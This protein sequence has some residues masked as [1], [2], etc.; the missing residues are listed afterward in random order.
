M[1]GAGTTRS[2]EGR[3][4]LEFEQYVLLCGEVLKTRSILRKNLSELHLAMTLA[5]SDHLFSWPRYNLVLVFLALDSPVTCRVFD[6]GSWSS[7]I[8][9]AFL[10]SVRVLQSATEASRLLFAIELILHSQFTVCIGNGK[11][12]LGSGHPKLFPNAL[13]PSICPVVTLGVH[14]CLFLDLLSQW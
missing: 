11:M 14:Y 3:R 13:T 4:Y 5:W 7:F 2:L 8:N 12:M 6:A 1:I 9:R 10:L